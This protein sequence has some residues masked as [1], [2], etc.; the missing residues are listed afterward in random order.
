MTAAAIQA[1]LVDVRNLGTEKCVKLT[2]HV[3][4]ELAMQVVDAFGWPTNVNPVPV[5]LARLN[6]NAGSASPAREA[7][8]VDHGQADSTA[9]RRPF[10]SLPL[11]QQAAL[12]CN[13][14]VFRAF[15]NEEHNYNCETADDAAE[16]VR[17]RCKVG[18]RSDIKP[19]TPAAAAFIRDREQFIAW[20]LVAA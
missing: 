13:D 2:L 15:L 10:A 7:V 12:L 9:S 18:S 6:L 16:A 3:P 17:E 20:K 11:P 1:Q 5:A 4:A 8:A 14:P 19:D